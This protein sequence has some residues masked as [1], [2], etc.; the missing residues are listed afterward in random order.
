MAKDIVLPL[1]III[2]PDSGLQLSFYSRVLE[3]SDLELFSELSYSV[4][5]AGWNSS[6][7]DLHLLSP[8]GTINSTGGAASSS[9]VDCLSRKESDTL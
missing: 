3:F 4:K 5:L 2:I 8:V 1:C 9:L 6:C 7:F